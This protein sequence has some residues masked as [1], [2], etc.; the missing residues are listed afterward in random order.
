MNFI[1]MLSALLSSASLVGM[2][3]QTPIK[4]FRTFTLKPTDRLEIEQS[5][6]VHLTSRIEPELPPPSIGTQVTS[7]LSSFIFG[8]TS[9]TDTPCTIQIMA[10]IDITKQIELPYSVVKDGNVMRVY[11]RSHLDKLGITLKEL[12]VTVPRDM[13]VVILK[14]AIE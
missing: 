4:I 6:L 2:Q 3:Q 5:L 8:Q 14:S 9:Q 13:T 7:T 1:V 11:L 10:L 12:I